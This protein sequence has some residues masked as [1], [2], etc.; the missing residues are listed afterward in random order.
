MTYCLGIKIAEGLIGLS[1]GRVTSGNQVTA[2]T[3]TVLLGPDGARFF[4]MTSGLRSLRDKTLAYLQ[5]HIRRSTNQRLPALLDVASAYADC[6]RQVEKE[7]REALQQ[8]QLGFD[9][10]AIIGGQLPDD[11]EPTMFL[12]YPEGN[13]VEVGERT[14]YLSIGATAYGKPILDR[15]LRQSTSMRVALKLAYLSFDSTRFSAANVGFPIDM[16]T[17]AAAERVWRHTQYDYD[18]LRDQRNWWNENITK[19]A[20]SMPDGPWVETLLSGT[21][22]PRLQVVQD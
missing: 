18:D 10:H 21:A 12:V 13:W 3:K 1:D 11:P 9:L 5:R 19:L 7:D 8:S 20:A 15:A 16:T 17:Y 6:L 2:A 22:R 14:P 4:I